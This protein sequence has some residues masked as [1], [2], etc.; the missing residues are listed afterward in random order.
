MSVPSRVRRVVT[1]E[2]RHTVWD[3]VSGADSPASQVQILPPLP[4]CQQVR[5]SFPL[6]EGLLL[7]SLVARCLAA[8]GME[9]PGSRDPV[10]PI[11]TIEHHG[12]SRWER[13]ARLEFVWRQRGRPLAMDIEGC[14]VP[15]SPH[16]AASFI[17]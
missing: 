14:G 17:G 6:G 1:E 12:E 4:T 16:P 15:G 2:T 10:R 9:S 7:S 8:I 13:P 3:R 5:G 11:V